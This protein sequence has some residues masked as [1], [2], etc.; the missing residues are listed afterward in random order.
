MTQ[1][2]NTADLWIREIHQGTV[3]LSFKVKKKLFSEQS[4]YQLVDIVDTFDH[5]RM[6]LNDGVIMLC[7]RDEFVYHEMIAHVP[8]FVHPNPQRVLVIGGGDGGTVREILKHDCVERVV[9]VE[10][11]PVVVNACRKYMPQ[12]SA[13]MEDPR[14][15]L[16]I[17]D[18]VEFVSRSSE[19]FDVAIVDSTDPV[20]PAKP[21][22]DSGFY[23]KIA[24]LLTP[25]GILITQAE[26]PYYDQE[27]QRGMLQNQR[28]HFN[29]LH[30]YLFTNLTYP[31]G[32]WSFGFASQGLCPLKNFDSVRIASSNIATRYYNAGIHRAA[33]MLPNF[34]RESLKDI[35]D[36]VDWMPPA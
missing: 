16:K 35:L 15:D 30:A 9:M 28:F 17:E 6:L 36:P 20:G 4:A 23:E 19:T 25:E 26:S 5:G 8:L 22:F 24:S 1:P 31:G 12:V 18:G 7:E 32:L 21:L 2:G 29:R 14:V 34:V 33:F 3:A 27:I 13:N 10:I 11:D